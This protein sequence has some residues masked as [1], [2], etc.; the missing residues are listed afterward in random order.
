MTMSRLTSTHATALYVGALLGPSLLLLPGLAARLAGPA[1]VLA[2]LAM[3]AVSGLLAW[4]F[5]ALG[6]R[7]RGG[8][9][10]AGYVA[11]GLGRRAGR[12]VGWCFVAGV[13]P[14]VP[15][16]CLIG[17]AYAAELLG[18]GRTTTVL[19]AA[20]LLA[21]VVTLTLGGARAGTAV[22]LVL[23]L[24]LVALVAVAVTGAAPSARAAHWTPFVPYGW[25]AIG[26]ASSA[27][28]MAF[29]GW[30]AIAPITAR[31]R[32]PRRQLP[33][34][35]GAAFV[36]TAVVYLALAVASVGVLGTA[37]GSDAP[38]ADLLRVALGAAGPVVAAVAAVATTLAVTNAYLTG[39][40][41][42]AAELT[43][44]RTRTH[45]L[46]IAVVVA[47][48]VLFGAFAARV[49]D[50]EQIVALPT[51]LFLAVYLG[52][53]VAAART[54]AGPVRL[55]AAVASLAVAVVLAFTGRAV[56]LPVLV[57]AATY[58]WSWRGARPRARHLCPDALGSG[59]RTG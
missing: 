35:I 59:E 25:S 55:A 1:S 4:V 34:V 42:L 53:T 20:V 27:L 19:A 9:G 39:A 36:V 57:V 16:V 6:T 50:T 30:E 18:G 5:A 46:Q 56:L 22:Q 26:S 12:A 51:A 14:G 24:V 2:W 23:V 11:A 54:L 29:I 3:L 43:G 21:V 28:M 10:V 58:A 45:W 48:V 41:A 37:A 32:D 38:L 15:L 52:C 13:V 31:L 33:R 8:D 7:F 44:K 49:V 17:G 40:A 47:G